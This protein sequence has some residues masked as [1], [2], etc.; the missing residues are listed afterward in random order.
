MAWIDLSCLISVPHNS[1]TL[2]LPLLPSVKAKCEEIHCDAKFLQHVDK[3]FG[4]SQFVS[5]EW[6]KERENGNAYVKLVAFNWV[7]CDRNRHHTM[8]HIH[9]LHYDVCKEK[10]VKLKHETRW[11]EYFHL[12]F[13]TFSFAFKSNYVFRLIWS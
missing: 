4:L 8:C 13:I 10:T 5:N 7:R 11:N 12:Y 6:K 3:K 2:P 1:D 9:S